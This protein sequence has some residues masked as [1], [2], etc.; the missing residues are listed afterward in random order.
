M[1]KLNLAS[2]L[3]LGGVIAL[4]ALLV[5]FG[6]YPPTMP[7]AWNYHGIQKKINLGLDLRGGAHVVLE[8]SP[9][10]EGQKVTKETIAETVEVLRMRIP[11]TLEPLV[12]GEGS[13]RVIVE[14]A[15]L[16]DPDAMIN[17]IIRPTVLEFKDDKGNIVVTGADLAS[18]KAGL[19]Q[20]GLPEIKLKF[21]SEGAKKFGDYTS[22]N[23]GK[24]LGI[25]IDGEL[26]ENPQIKDAITSGDAV[27]S[28]GWK[29]GELDKATAV[30]R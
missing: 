15:G 14:V 1:Q 6:F 9:M 4:V 20:G 17:N 18:A 8:A 25:Y 13:D 22:A 23:I 27:I 5:W 30:A 12:Q 11:V 7:K 19:D 28:G 2:V 29:S 10:K 26:R 24:N 21:K 3:K 16:D